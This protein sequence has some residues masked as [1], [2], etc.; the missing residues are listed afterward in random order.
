MMK[1]AVALLL[2][3]L[4][5]LPCIAACSKPANDKGAYIRMYLNEKIY[6]FDPLSAFENA[7]NLQIVSMLFS[8]LFYAD[9]DGEPQKD[10]VEEYEYIYDEKEDRYYLT[11]TLRDTLWSDGVPLTAMHVQYAFLRLFSSDLSHPATAMLYDIKNAR[12]VVNGENPDHLQ[13]IVVNS[14]ELEIEFEKDIDIN[15]FL[16]TLCSPALYPVRDDIVESNKD[17]AKKTTTMVF[18]GPFIVRKMNYDEKDGFILERNAYYLRDRQEDDLDEYVTPYRLV[19]DYTTPIEDQLAKFDAEDAGALYYLGN[20]PVSGRSTAAFSALLEKGELT[21]STST[22]VY[23]MNEKALINGTALFADPAV[24]KA[25]SLALDREAIA[26]ALV[27]AKAADALVPG[28]ILN[29]AGD[30]ETFREA[31][32]EGIATLPNVKLAKAMLDAAGI[33][34]S[35]YAFSI[36][37]AEYDTDHV[38]TAELAKAAW[39]ALGFK[40]SIK[41]L[42]VETAYQLDENGNQVLDSKTKKPIEMGYVND[43]YKDAYKA[44]NFEIIALDLVSPGADAFSYLAPFA[45]AFSGN[46]M[47]MNT[48]T[49]P[50]YK[51]TP[52]IT[53]YQS[54][55]YD[56]KIEAAFAEQDQEKRAA[57]LHEAEEILLSDMPVIP[58]VYNMNFS[59]ASG[60]LGKI[61]RR[62][63]C[64]AHFQKTSLSGYWEIALA[65]KFVEELPATED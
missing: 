40:V 11:M 23:Y 17:W 13:V 15:A 59:L 53:G 19:C 42:G 31:A 45:T 21:E 43:L 47:D 54:A 26:E 38:A 7:D 36:T 34:P 60:E 33:T 65:E 9:E 35:D 37:V 56:Q 32:R 12:D 5:L 39:S 51:L 46:A 62:F 18:S 29:R 8:G 41:K 1:R 49:N 3:L 4:M 63:F 55:A 44:G 57:L 16:L 14:K 28:A 52:H 2:C 30:D 64:N 22:H 24:R 27:F 61:E 20:I 25:L 6:D 50:E 10:L 58:V 48:E